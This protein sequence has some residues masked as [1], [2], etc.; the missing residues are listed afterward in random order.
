MLR[1]AP[2]SRQVKI[3]RA[4][5]NAVI[6]PGMGERV[7][8]HVTPGPRLWIALHLRGDE[9]AGSLSVPPLPLSLSHT[10]ELSMRGGRESNWKG[11]REEKVALNSVFMTPSPR[12][13][14]LTENLYRFIRAIDGGGD[15][16]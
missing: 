11:E 2:L 5:P 12:C 13:G 9:E 4:G 14:K 3:P 7:F 6:S 10:G 8:R 1:T 16:S 15:R